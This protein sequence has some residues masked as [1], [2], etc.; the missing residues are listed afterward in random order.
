MIS[1]TPAKSH[2]QRSSGSRARPEIKLW[3]RG[4]HGAL[5]CRRAYGIAQSR[6]SQSVRAMPEAAGRERNTHSWLAID[7]LCSCCCCCCWREARVAGRR[8]TA[9]RHGSGG[10]A[11]SV[12]VAFRPLCHAPDKMDEP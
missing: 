6:S 9:Q 1:P 12:T 10:P 4:A 2:S 8:G 7:M 11:P 5:V 3:Q